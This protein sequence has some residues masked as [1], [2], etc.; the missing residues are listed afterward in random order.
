MGF[1]DFLFA[2][3]RESRLMEDKTSRAVAIVVSYTPNAECD[4]PNYG[5]A[6][7]KMKKDEAWE[8]FEVVLVEDFGTLVAGEQWI[9]KCD[10]GFGRIV[11]PQLKLS[12]KSVYRIADAD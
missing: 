6:V 11:T 1:F 5:K 2:E 9:V 3:K 12:K 7:F 4:T 8:E 10:E